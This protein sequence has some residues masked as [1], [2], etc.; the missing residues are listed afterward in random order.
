MS[1][2]VERAY[3][4]TKLTLL[5]ILVTLMLVSTNY[6]SCAQITAVAPVT[7]AGSSNGVIGACPSELIRED[8]RST[9]QQEVR[10][11]LKIFTQNQQRGGGRH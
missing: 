4:M 2:H 8:L 10:T 1:V 3:N 5:Q 6:L 11:Q 9:L 7:L